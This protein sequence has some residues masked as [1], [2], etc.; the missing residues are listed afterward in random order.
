[1]G[2]IRIYRLNA[3]TGAWCSLTDIDLPLDGRYVRGSQCTYRC[4]VLPD[5]LRGILPT[6]SPPSQCTY[7]CV[8]LPDFVP[9][10]L[11]EEDMWSQCTYR[12]VVL[13]DIVWSTRWV[14]SPT[15]LNAPTG[16]WCSLTMFPKVDASSSMS[17]CTYRCVVLPDVSSQ[18]TPWRGLRLNAPTGAWCS[19]TCRPRRHPGVACVSMHLQVRGAP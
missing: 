8:V 19:L 11:E 1:M 14:L 12:C 17:Q 2:R 9:M 7:R 16:A 6:G 4:A 5:W 18:T 3:P 15:C 10:T 13:P